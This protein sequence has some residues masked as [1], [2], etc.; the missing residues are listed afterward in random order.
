MSKKPPAKKVRV[1][2]VKKLAAM[3]CTLLE[4]AGFLG[5]REHTLK[6]LKATDERI[7][8]AL[9]EGKQLGKISLRR[10]QWRLATV[11]PSMAIHLGK[12]YLDQKDVQKHEH[13]GADGGP[14]ETVDVS[15]LSKAERN[16]LRR[17]LDRAAGSG[18][19]QR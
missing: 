11:N 19:A 16:E 10:K 1:A 12:H 3:Q 5:I 17:L 7:R 18:Q 14:I 6:R 9:E 2:D 8:K 4:I 15:K 13:T